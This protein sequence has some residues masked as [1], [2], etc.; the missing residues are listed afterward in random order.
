MTI[1][2][3][4]KKLH[5]LE[6]CYLRKNYLLDIPPFLLEMDKLK[7]LF[8][9]KNP[10]EDNPTLAVIKHFLQSEMEFKGGEA[11]LNLLRYMQKR[12]PKEN[13]TSNKKYFSLQIEKKL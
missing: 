6:T 5:K 7:E 1:P 11:V 12:T 3:S 10:F 13:I 4:F 8:I 2:P 9:A